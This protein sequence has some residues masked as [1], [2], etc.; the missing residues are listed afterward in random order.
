MADVALSGLTV[1][2][3]EIGEIRR[4]IRVSPTSVISRWRITKRLFN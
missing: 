3:R 2:H 1:A 4:R